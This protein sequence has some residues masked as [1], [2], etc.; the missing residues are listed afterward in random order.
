MT[1]VLGVRFQVSG[2]RGEGSDHEELY[3][4]GGQRIE[5]R[6]RRSEGRRQTTEGRGQN[7]ESRNYSIAVVLL[8][9]F[10]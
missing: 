9:R 7:C 1:K 10:E 6:G 2:V 5:L 8:E 3:G 4:C